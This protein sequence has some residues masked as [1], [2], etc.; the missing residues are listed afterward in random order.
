MKE[1]F[2]IM[3][4]SLN[5]LDIL[6]M[7]V[8]TSEESSESRTVKENEMSCAKQAYSCQN[9]ENTTVSRRKKRS[10]TGNRSKQFFLFFSGKY[11]LKN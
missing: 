8:S 1:K 5:I 9:Q 11:F 2:Q 10:V 3:D 6:N 4:S 7:V